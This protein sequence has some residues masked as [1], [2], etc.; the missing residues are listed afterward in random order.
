M[1]DLF[2]QIM[3]RHKEKEIV[4]LCKKCVKKLSFKSGTDVSNLCDLCFWL[5]IFG[6]HDTVFKVAGLTHDL[7]FDH[8]FSVWEPIHPKISAKTLAPLLSFPVTV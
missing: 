6:D 1:Q 8:N 5:F 3:A 2:E 4:S 7:P